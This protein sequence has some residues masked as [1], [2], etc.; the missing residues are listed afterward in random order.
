[1]QEAPDV[2]N[3]FIKKQLKKEI[4]EKK[5]LQPNQDNEAR[6]LNVR[7]DTRPQTFIQPWG[8]HSYHEHRLHAWRQNQC[9]P[10]AYDK[11]R[12]P[13]KSGNG[14]IQRYCAYILRA[15]QALVAKLGK[16]YHGPKGRTS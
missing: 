8:A 9:E 10:R 7:P 1:M 4:N 2:A 11:V 6:E 12:T 15:I 14:K 5:H 13:G 3:W 16:L